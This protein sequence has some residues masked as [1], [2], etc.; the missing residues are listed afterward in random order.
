MAACVT[1]SRDQRRH[2][3]TTQP[4]ACGSSASTDSCG[5]TSTCGTPGLVLQAVYDNCGAQEI[6][7]YAGTPASIAAAVAAYQAAAAA[8][9]AL[10]GLNDA[11]GSTL[12]WGYPAGNPQAAILLDDTFGSGLGAY[13]DS[14]AEAIEVTDAFGVLI[15][16]A[17]AGGTTVPNLC[18]T[19]APR[20]VGATFATND[21][22]RGLALNILL[23]DAPPL[24]TGGC[25]AT[26]GKRG[27]YWADDYRT[28]RLYTGSRLRQL[29][30]AGTTAALAT[31]IGQTATQD[32]G[33]LISYGI[34]SSI[35][36]TATYLGGGSYKLQVEIDG[37]S[38]SVNGSKVANDW[39]WSV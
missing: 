14:A 28:D 8:A 2:F 15:G 1:T 31:L 32:L 35:V 3:W 27:G 23:T 7:C 6:G 30:T 38:F 33:K 19:P 21:F 37:Q 11:F 24:P 39:F 12:A 10:I 26:P 34:A 20:L 5:N 17:S 13:L 22:V 4:D 9:L 16:Y 25:S 18:S 29:T 36:A